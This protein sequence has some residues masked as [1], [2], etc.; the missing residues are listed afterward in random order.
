MSFPTLIAPKPQVLQNLE[1]LLSQAAAFKRNPTRRSAIGKGKT[2]GLVFLNPSL[3]TR[4]S[5]QKAALNL[6]MQ[7]LDFDATKG[8]GWETEIA[9]VMNGHKAEHLKEAVGVLSSYCDVLGLRSF[10]SLQDQVADY[11]DRFFHQFEQYSSAP[12]LNLESAIR[13]PLQGLTDLMTIREHQTHAK[14]KVV[15]SWAPH[16]KALPQAVPNSF[17]ET[18][19]AGGVDLHICQPKG[20]ELDPIFTEGATI[21]YVQNEAFEGADFIYAKNWSALQ[22]YGKGSNQHNDWIITSL[23]MALTSQA[24]FMHC[25]PVRRNVVVTD[26]VMDSSKSLVIPQAA[27]REFIAQSVLYQ[28]L[29]NQ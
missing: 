14:P 8:W 7:V 2:L 4:L 19:L 21:H 3:R 11:E 29:Q 25:L 24:H 28:T 20:F 9:T 27:N 12:V 18:M 6:G 15:L 17:A 1:T 5:T 23:K 26:A 16:P 22:P 10:A 13:H